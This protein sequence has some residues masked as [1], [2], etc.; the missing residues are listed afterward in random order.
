MTRGLNHCLMCG[1][2]I[3][4]KNQKVVEFLKHKYFIHV[5]CEPK[6]RVE[7]TKAIDN[8]NQTYFLISN[9]KK[10]LDEKYVGIFERKVWLSGGAQIALWARTIGMQQNNDEDYKYEMT[11]TVFEKIFNCKLEQ[12][13]IEREENS[14][15]IYIDEESD[16]HKLI[17]G[18]GGS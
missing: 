17:D 9:K 15:V 8:M 10:E 4:K 13:S 5:A 6:Y 11:F 2:G 12:P 1:I 3:T 14:M 16:L 18:I 7:A